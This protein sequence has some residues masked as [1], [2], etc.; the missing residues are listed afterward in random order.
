MKPDNPLGAIEHLRLDFYGNKYRTTLDN[1]ITPDF[2]QDGIRPVVRGQVS[3]AVGVELG[4]SIAISLLTSIA[5]NL[6]VEVI[7]AV[8]RKI[9]KATGETL[10]CDC[11]LG[12]LTIETAACDYVIIANSDAGT[13]AENI[14]YGG[15]VSQMRRLC[16]REL[17]AGRSIYRIETPCDMDPNTDSLTIRTNGVGS[18]SLWLITYRDGDRWPFCLYDAINGALIP[19][20]NRQVVA[21]A[22]SGEDI[23]Y[24]VNENP[25]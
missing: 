22:I 13:H 4:V 19:L 17:A 12:R 10:S 3:P 5:S 24:T 2:L 11:H 8:M 20:D 6:V 16:E 18:Y 23:F 9:R 1:Y 14:D 21:G 25:L 15:L 7:K